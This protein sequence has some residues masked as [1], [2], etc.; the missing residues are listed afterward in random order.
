V[1]LDVFVGSFDIGAGGPGTTKSVTGLPFQPKV[2]IFQWS[3]LF[4]PGQAQVRHSQSLG[5]MVSASDRGGIATTSSHSAATASSAHI[6]Y[7][8]QAIIK[9]IVSGGLPVVQSS[10]DFDAFLSDGFRLLI[11]FA[12]SGGMLVNYIALGGVDLTNVASTTVT[13]P[14][15]AIPDGDTQ[16]IS[17]GFRPDCVISFGPQDAAINT[18]LLGKKLQLGV[19]A[20][21]QVDGP[22]NAV[23]WG[24][25]QNG[26][27]DTI[28]GC[29]SRRGDCFVDLSSADP[30]TNTRGQVVRFLDNGF[31]I[32]WNEHTAPGVSLNWRVLCLKGARFSVGFAETSTETGS[33][34]FV[35]DVPFE[36]KALILG[37]HGKPESVTVGPT[38][39]VD[40]DDKETIG[41][42]S[43]SAQNLVA[44]L[45][46]NNLATSQVGIDHRLDA[47]YASQVGFPSP[48]DPIV[49]DGRASLFSFDDDPG[50]T[51][52]QDDGDA[53]SSFF[54]YLAMT[55]AV[56][57]GVAGAFALPDS[58]PHSLLQQFAST[59]APS[60]T[61]D[62][63]PHSL[64]T[65]FSPPAIE[66]TPIYFGGPSSMLFNIPVTLV[67]R[68]QLPVDWAGTLGTRRAQIP[69]E[70]QEVPRRRATLPVEWLGVLR[71]RAQIPID[72]SGFVVR[73]CT[74]PVEW[75]GFV[76]RRATIPIEW[77][78][79]LARR[80]QIPVE[81][82][83][84]LA[85]RA[86]LPVEWQGV[87]Q[88]RATMP[89]EWNSVINRR[90]LIPVEWQGEIRRRGEI[91]VE[92]TGQVQTAVTRRAELPVEWSSQVPQGGLV[93]G[94]GGP[95][96]GAAEETY[97]SE[98][99]LRFEGETLVRWSPIHRV[100]AEKPP[101]RKPR[102]RPAPVIP[103]VQAEPFLDALRISVGSPR[104]AGSTLA[105]WEPWVGVQE[106]DDE[107]ALL[108]VLFE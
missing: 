2:V 7:S 95:P 23:L 103:V 107:A 11:N 18:P 12:F 105:R 44:I 27:A 108:A 39:P 32:R 15:T 51:L 31:R 60:A 62:S 94:G 56:P 42:A 37:S 66:W 86:T 54:W 50:F 53:V 47:L 33:K 80:A 73:R 57:V 61:P 43:A 78:G 81:W 30:T 92:W 25:S 84:V 90:A 83:G 79:V 35:E 5:Y 17:V 21:N 69:V 48:L 85:R 87:L 89:V 41:F 19:A 75:A 45:D 46:R 71:R 40:A 4:V 63:V 96:I 26:V 52:T 91:P 3:G 67:R 10:A 101:R 82:Q 34:R 36:P 1:A 65:P 70:W 106:S 24:D 6:G 104:W 59:P 49:E 76:T 74:I 100:P 9:V 13:A 98:A 77:Q 8:N 28:T 55:D 88:R 102:P 64:I 72:W 93:L 68:A 22:I 99:W 58:V 14:A 38:Q 29:Y 97:L 16:D 20:G